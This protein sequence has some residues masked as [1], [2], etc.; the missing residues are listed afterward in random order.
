[1]SWRPYKEGDRVDIANAVYGD[2][3]EMEIMFTQVRT[4][5]NE[6]VHGR[7][8]RFSATRS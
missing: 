5:K 4:I 2:V 7:T 8:R 1:M 3:V 6:I